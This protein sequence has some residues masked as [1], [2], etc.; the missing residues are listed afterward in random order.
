MNLTDPK[1]HVSGPR[2]A[3]IEPDKAQA[4]IDI[5]EAILGAILLDPTAFYR[6]STKLRPEHFYATLHQH[7]F[8][9]C[10]ALAAAGHA[11]CDMIMVKGLLTDRNIDAPMVWL[12]GLVDRTIS[13]ANVDFYAE[14]IIDR[15]QKREIAL[16][17][18]R[19]ANQIAKGDK[20]HDVLSTGLARLVELSQVAETRWQTL[21]YAAQELI[22]HNDRLWRGEIASPIMP[23]RIES[24]DRVLGGG[25]ERGEIIVIAG[26]SGTGK[27][28]AMVQASIAMAQPQING[29]EIQPGYKIG[30]FSMEM[31]PPKLLRRA[32]VTATGIS[33]QR[34]RSM[35]VTAPELHRINDTL[36]NMR[37][38]CGSNYHFR[39]GPLQIDELCLEARAAIAQHK[40]DAIWVDHVHNIP[41]AESVELFNKICSSLQQ[42][43]QETGVTLLLLAQLNE[44]RGEDKRP[45]D[46]SLLGSKALRNIA[47]AVI[48]LHRP[49]KEDPGNDLDRG[50]IEVIGAKLRE[51]GGLNGEIRPIV[52]ALFDG[53][54]AAIRGIS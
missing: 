8:R 9:T 1:A 14:I 19:L 16:L 29:D 23:T 13:T 11:T 47:D 33:T 44:I 39:Y 51:G 17:S 48:I 50:I 37:A 28:I 18:V 53:E 27:T 5:E 7:V 25:A 45:T 32:A 21:G 52:R 41:G 3:R 4:N 38:N 42:L 20:A 24:I 35:Q 26:R 43:A 34:Q 22:D 10:S 40:L 15:W 54:N 30:V 2:M 6:V 31:T 49:E 12:A 46:Q 36:G